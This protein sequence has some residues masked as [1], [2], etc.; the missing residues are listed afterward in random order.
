MFKTAKDL[1]FLKVGDVPETGLE[2]VVMTLRL[3]GCNA[4]TPQPFKVAEEVVK[5]PCPVVVSSDSDSVSLKENVQSINRFKAFLSDHLSQPDHDVKIPK[6]EANVPSAAS[7]PNTPKRT[8]NMKTAS[9]SSV[10][11]AEKAQ[12][13]QAD[14]GAIP[15]E[16]LLITNLEQIKYFKRYQ[17]KKRSHQERSKDIYEIKIMDRHG[18]SKRCRYT[19]DPDEVLPSL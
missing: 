8:A 15:A 1:G 7:I 9:H 12:D 14:A 19:E 18:K 4:I 13:Q 2:D 10:N 3:L 11:A 5:T 17:Q 6:T 16:A